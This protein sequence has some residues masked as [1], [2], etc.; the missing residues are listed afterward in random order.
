MLQQ[1]LCHLLRT[2]NELLQ[3]KSNFALN[4]YLDL[5][6]CKE[7]QKSDAKYTCFSGKHEVDHFAHAFS[8]KLLHPFLA[9]LC[10]RFQFSNQLQGIY[11]FISLN[12]S[13]DSWEVFSYFL[14]CY[15]GSRNQQYSQISWQCKSWLHSSVISTNCQI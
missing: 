13:G 12:N 1:F 5:V 8:L 14:K 9:S 3:N 7:K 6:C 11:P 10:F 2:T 15:L 4:E